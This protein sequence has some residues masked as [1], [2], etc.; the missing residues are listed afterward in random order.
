MKK[1]VVV[2]MGYVGLSNAL[3]LSK[4]NCVVGIDIS[5]DK[6]NE[7]KV[8]KSPIE[9]DLVKEYLQRDDLDISFS[10]QLAPHA[11]D[12]DFLLIATPTNFDTNSN[13]FDTKSI[14]DVISAVVEVNQT[15]CIVIKSTIPIGFTNSIRAKYPSQNIIFSPEFLREGCALEDCLNPT[16]IIIGANCTNSQAL[17]DLFTTAADKED[18]PVHFVGSNEAEAIKLF[19]NCYLAMRVAFFNELDTYALESGLNT[20]DLVL[21]VSSDPR[22]GF[23]YNNPSFGYGGY[24]LPKDTKQLQSNFA[25]VPEK[26]ITAIIESNE[27]RLDYVAQ[28]I[29]ELADG[30]TG[31]YRL[32]MK[33]GSDNYRESASLKLALKLNELGVSTLIYEPNCPLTQIEGIQ[34][35]NEL[36]EFKRR[37]VSV[38]AN[39]I[40]HDISD[41]NERVFTRDLF[42]FN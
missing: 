36:D 14:Q 23:Y 2:G 9:E 37:C 18:V 39:R 41:I 7:L 10:D 32:A 20:E 1:I 29:S 34:V 28:K 31:I 4:E 12:A 42:N 13:Y 30:V 35:C 11:S 38:V 27:T 33:A 3:M 17:A 6:V 24:C 26:L 5:H 40:D 22:I 16:R 25:N 19:A 15:C 21:G 8:G